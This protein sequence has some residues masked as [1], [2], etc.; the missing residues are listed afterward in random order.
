[1]VSSYKYKRY[2][3][4]T[5][6]VSNSII[7]GDIFM[8]I[9]NI[10][11]YT[12]LNTKILYYKNDE[13]IFAKDYKIK[14]KYYYCISSYKVKTNTVEEICRYEIPES[15]FYSQ[16]IHIVGEEIIMI[17]MHFTHKIEIDILNKIT[18]ETKSKHSIEIKKEITSI[19]IIINSQI[20][21]FF[22]T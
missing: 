18:K 5:T 10:K 1:M 12:G 17:K 13:V 9:I 11:P 6:I 15:E 14:E 16:Y 19:P 4:L 3:I 8:K 22:I 20:I 7:R 2:I 21:F